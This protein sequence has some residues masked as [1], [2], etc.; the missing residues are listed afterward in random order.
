VH[1][2]VTDTL[3]KPI[4]GA[5]VTVKG[6]KTSA[7]TSPD[8]NFSIK[9][10]MG[11]VLNVSAVGFSNNE[12]T[13]TSLTNV[14]ISLTA[15]INSLNDVVV[16]GY[17]TQRKASITGAISTI[18][19][20]EITKTPATTTS[21]ALVGKVPGITARATDSRPGNGVNLQIRNLGNPLYVIDGIPYNTNYSTT[22]FGYSKMVKMYLIV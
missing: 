17:G 22:G 2:S 4:I 6:T 3:K 13:V 10:K 9:A 12:I 21:A 18:N 19:S 1:G 20:G 8:G 11:D 14:N 16:V 7:I 5:T 15:T